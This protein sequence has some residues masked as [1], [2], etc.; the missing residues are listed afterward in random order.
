MFSCTQGITTWCA[1]LKR[2]MADINIH[3]NG[4]IYTLQRFET[5]C[6][7]NQNASHQPVQPFYHSLKNFTL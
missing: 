2:I 6:V 1:K 5:L 7:G 4:L 3:E